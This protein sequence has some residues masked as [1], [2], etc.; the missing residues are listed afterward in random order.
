MKRVCF[1]RSH[2]PLKSV[3]TDSPGSL[4]YFS[5][6]QRDH[7]IITS[8]WRRRFQPN[9]FQKQTSCEHSHPSR[10]PALCPAAQPEPF[11]PGTPHPLTPAL[12]AMTFTAQLLCQFSLPFQPPGFPELPWGI[13][14]CKKCY[15]WM[16]LQ[17]LHLAI[18]LWLW[19][20]EM[21]FSKMH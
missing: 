5:R 12:Q 19:Q 11:S 8:V 2:H 16:Q 18:S 13:S 6:L 9:E 4:T 1:C 20:Y 14:V 21:L 17:T 10:T 15:L 3:C 7:L